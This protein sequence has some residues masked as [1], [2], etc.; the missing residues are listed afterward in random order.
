ML[1]VSKNI[2]ERQSVQAALALVL[3]LFLA[4]GLTGCREAAQVEVQ[5]SSRNVRVLELAPDTLAEYFEI[6]G[7]VAPVRGTELS[8]QES[9]PVVEIMAPKGAVVEA[10]ESL[11]LQERDIL[12]AQRE[13]AA[14]ALAT[15]AYNLDKVQKLFDAGKVSRIE[16]LNSETQYQGAKAQ[17]DIS[18]ERYDRALIKAPYGGVV[19]D[20]FVELGQMVQP[21]QPV[22]RFIDPYTLK[23]EGYL[24][25]NQIGWAREGV[26]AEVNLG[27]DGQTAAGNVSWVGMEADR[28]TGK[29][30]VEIQIPNPDLEYRSGVIGRAR[31]PKNINRDVVTIPRDAI[32]EGRHGQEVFVVRSDRAHRQAI[33]LGPDQGAM[34]MVTEGLKAGDLLVVR[35]HRELVEGSLVQIT[36][37]A[38][39]PDGSVESD[40]AV[41]GGNGAGASR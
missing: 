5:E 11:L 1:F 40:P 30:K 9:G 28:M 22:V 6:T 7:P 37:R 24:T 8:A 27:D 21:G 33:T 12:L 25:G 26:A 18:A 38:T 17:A 29:F 14:A 10:G 23:L 20:R 19:A 32:M 31:I 4:V 41:L 35:G 16:L 3:A 34:V 36:E 2:S 13:A 39:S 15:Q